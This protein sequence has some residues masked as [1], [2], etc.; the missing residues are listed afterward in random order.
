M[1]QVS[2]TFYLIIQSLETQ[3][4]IYFKILFIGLS[5][6]DDRLEYFM[7]QL[8]EKVFVTLHQLKGKCHLLSEGG[9]EYLL[10]ST[11]SD[12]VAKFPLFSFFLEETTY[13]KEKL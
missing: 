8:W 4:Q 10:G 7:W 11:R 12:T 9:V 6:V 13:L 2:F 5:Y 1:D 3:K